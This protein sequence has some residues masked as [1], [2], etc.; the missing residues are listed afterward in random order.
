[1]QS[2]F[3][4]QE[5][6]QGDRSVKLCYVLWAECDSYCSMAIELPNLPHFPL[7]FSM[8]QEWLFLPT[9]SQV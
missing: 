9:L 8:E 2:A 7:L 6:E 5:K 1:M 4:N 3:H